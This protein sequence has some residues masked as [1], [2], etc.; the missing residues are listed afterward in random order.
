MV[1]ESVLKVGGKALT[2]VKTY[3]K[4]MCKIRTMESGLKL[5]PPLER[6]SLRFTSTIFGD[7]SDGKLINGS[8][9][10]NLKLPNGNISE[11]SLILV[12]MDN[13]LPQNGILRTT[14]DKLTG[15]YGS[16]G[17]R[18]S[19][20]FSL[21][22]VVDDVDGLWSWNN[23]KYSYI[24][25]Y[26]KVNNLVGGSPVDMFT[27]GSVKIPEGSYIVRQNTSIPAGKYRIMD[28]SEIEEF[29]QLQ[30]VKIIETADLPYNVTNTMIEKLG[31]EVKPGGS[32]SW[33][34]EIDYDFLKF[35][36]NKN[37]FS[38]IHAH[39]PNSKV[40]MLIDKIGMRAHFNL[41]WGVT[42]T[43]GK[44]ENYYQK[45]ALACLEQIET[46]AK[47]EHYPLD[48]DTKTLRQIIQNSSTPK[49]A[50]TQIRRELKLTNMFDCSNAFYLDENAFYNDFSIRVG[51][52][53]PKNIEFNK[54]YIDFIKGKSESNK[55]DFIEK[56]NK[57][58]GLSLSV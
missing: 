45:E 43:G 36:K 23:T 58:F 5:A 55:K 15:E 10:K 33:A 1:I 39:T 2:Q 35:L 30:G 42:T 47:T 44:L 34:D 31:Y 14:R 51:S 50:I 22:G 46:L 11:D 56:I 12:R 19:L 25:P 7:L 41:D 17:A 3:V 29:S 8:I 53:N 57:V 4:P 32:F 24:I 20:H 40:E 26:R 28:V 9:R 37:L 54:L 27:K 6:D 13:D 49:D 52:S 38:A 18:D 21:N 48:F 16:K